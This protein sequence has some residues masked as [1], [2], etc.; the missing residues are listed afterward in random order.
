MEIEATCIHYAEL[1]DY[2]IQTEMSPHPEP[3]PL[4]REKMKVGKITL[5]LDGDSNRARSGFYPH[6]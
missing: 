6:R 4:Q 2:C 3:L 1:L 5:N